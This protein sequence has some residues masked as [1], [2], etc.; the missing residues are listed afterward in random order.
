MTAVFATIP[1]VDLA[2]AVVDRVRDAILR[3]ELE[4]GAVLP[5]E[6]DLAVQLGVN[7]TTVREG[8][9]RLEHLGLIDRRQG[10]R[11]RVCDYRRTGSLELLP[12]LARLGR[13][14]VGPSINEANGIVYEGTV[15]LAAERATEADAAELARLADVVEHA[16]AGGVVADISQAD[17][18]FQHAVAAAARSVALELMVS[19]F[20]RSM[21][22]SLDAR[23]RVKR[24][25]AQ[26][27]IDL[28]R[29]GR[30]LPHR[31]LA[32]AIAGGDAVR[33]RTIAARVMAATGAPTTRAPKR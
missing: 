24:S 21:D 1:K 5:S 7:R 23:G 28:R 33:A 2:D 32:E 19:N 25:T 4:P 30:P 27:L 13:K 14:D 9:A 6:R 17:R 11:C 12:A 3:D 20:Y 22:L 29:S 16:V 15:G 18:A 31:R 10:T 8:L 26:M